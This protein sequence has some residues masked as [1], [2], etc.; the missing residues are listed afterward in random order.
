MALT[1]TA[2]QGFEY[3]RAV[4][5]GETIWVPGDPG[6]TF[7]RGDLVTFSV[8]EGVADPAAT[9]EV[10][11]GV[12]RNTVVCPAATAAGF[13][14]FGP[15]ATHG[16]GMIPDDSWKTLVEITPFVP[17]GTP[18]RR[19]TFASH[20][21]DTVASYLATTPYIGLTTGAA[22]DDYP[23]GA[24]LYVYSGTGKG[25]WS[26]VEDYDHTGGAVELLLN[27][28]RKFTTALSTDSL[29]I[30]LSG[31]AATNKGV[32]F[33]GRTGSADGNNV[34]VNDH[35]NDGAMVVYANA[36]ELHEYIPRLMLPVI[37]AAL[38]LLA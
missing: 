32:G 28:H 6:D 30:I 18:I 8:G 17:P 34:A 31:E 5:D 36:L 4:A 1:A 19:V 22:A 12:V 38:V 35:A 23:N 25:Q 13:P 14:V 26:V 16:P 24:L 7:T 37:P 15:G 29:V 2:S 21:D 10:P 11:F 27:P 20:L 9:N 33:F 3:V